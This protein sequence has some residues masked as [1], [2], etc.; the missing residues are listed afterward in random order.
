MIIMFAIGFTSFCV[1]GTMWIIC[2]LLHRPLFGTG[3]I[4]SR[5]NQLEKNAILEEEQAAVTTATWTI[6]NPPS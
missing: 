6:L 2:N 3:D 4:K 5:K 1:V